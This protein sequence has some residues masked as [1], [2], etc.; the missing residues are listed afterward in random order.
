MAGHDEHRYRAT[1]IWDGAA[2]PTRD[3]ESYSRDYRVEVPGRPTIGG[4]ADAAF[5]GNPGL[6]N[7]EDLMVAA[8]S[9]CHMLWYL[10]LCAVKGVVV[11]RYED[12]AEGVMV[13]EPGN[14]RF[15]AVTLRPIVTIT[16]DSDAAKAEALHARAHAECFIANSVNFPI[17]CEPTI[18]K[19]DDA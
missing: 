14:G 2:A 5:G 16:A 18:V 10:H 15:T 17:H 9:A 19:A 4:S 12:S 1:T 11:T 3:Y 13:A 8:L 7:P 6:H